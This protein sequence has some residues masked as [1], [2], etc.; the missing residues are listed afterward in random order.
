MANAVEKKIYNEIRPDEQARGDNILVCL[1]NDYNK[2]EKLIRRT[3]RIA[4]RFDSRWY[5]IYVE[6]AA[7]SFEKLELK[8]QRHLINNF[9]LASELGGL[10][11]KIQ[12]EDV[13]QGILNY[14]KEKLVSKIILGKP[15]IRNYFSKI[16]HGNIID[17][18]LDKVD[19]EKAE[20]DI[21][22]LS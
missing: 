15:A 8:L 5:V 20:Y 3:A 22:I 4:E 7:N 10:S 17:K 21:E 12:S 16:V 1:G 14:A 2:N 13:I 19:K 18:L 11:E 9:K 6:S